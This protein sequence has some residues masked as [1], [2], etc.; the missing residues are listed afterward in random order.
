MRIERIAVADQV[1]NAIAVGDQQCRRGQAA[2][3]FFTLENQVGVAVVGFNLPG[4]WRGK[5]LY[6]DDTTD[7]RHEL[8]T[9]KL[10]FNQVA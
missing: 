9:G 1:V 2:D 7:Y 6:V 8:A 4:T 10:G 3:V 5:A